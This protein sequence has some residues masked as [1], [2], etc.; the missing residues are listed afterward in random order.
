VVSDIYETALSGL[1]TSFKIA[2][3]RKKAKLLNEIGC[4]HARFGNEKEAEKTFKSCMDEFPDFSASFVNCANIKVCNRQIDEAILILKKGMKK[5]PDS[6][7]MNLLLARCYYMKGNQKET[8]KYLS[9]VK[10]RSPE[11]AQ[12]Y[13]YLEAGS[14]TR[15]GTETDE[16]PFIWVREE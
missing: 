8:A 14:Q 4:L 5:N 1:E 6:V 9:V 15:A 7:F 10:E 2:S 11:L 12:R 16:T 13:A 3:G